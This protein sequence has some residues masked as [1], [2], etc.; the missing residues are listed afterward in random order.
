MW[1]TLGNG[2]SIELYFCDDNSKVYEN[3]NEKEDKMKIMSNI[4]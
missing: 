3:P 2:F 1:K 4:R